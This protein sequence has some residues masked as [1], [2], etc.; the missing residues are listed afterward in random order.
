MPTPIPTTSVL[1]TT[2]LPEPRGPL[3]EALFA[4]LRGNVG[5]LP[6]AVAGHGITDD[7]LYGEDTPLALYTLY[8]LH[9]R[10]FAGAGEGWE[11]D[12]EI[13][14]LRSRLEHAFL[15]RLTDEVGERFGRASTSPCAVAHELQSLADADGPS[16]S[17]FMATEGT[18]EH[19]REFVV[20]RSPYQLKEADPHTWAIPRLRGAAKAALVTIQTDEYGGGHQGAMHSE[21]FAEAMHSLGL[22]ARYGALLESVPGATLS[23]VNLVSLFGL[24]RRWRGALIGHLALFEMCSISPMGRYVEALHRMGA[25]GATPFYAAHV[26]ADGWHEKIALDDMVGN[27]VRDEPAL[28]GDVVFGARA[29]DHLERG[30]THR[31]LSAWSCGA[32]SL[33]RGQVLAP[34]R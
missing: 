3:T 4:S 2:R 16:L 12:P 22:D 25:P 18:I 33:R 30:L 31:L 24:H 23:T 1:T 9:Y 7:P 17:M 34:S 10:G 32:S 19:M 6:R 27:F 20:H 29:L 28:S 5:T 8:E 21:L 26:V 15:T 11:W 14:R 13:L